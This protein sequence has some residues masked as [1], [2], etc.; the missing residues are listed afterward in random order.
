MQEENKELKE[1]M[2]NI[3]NLYVIDKIF[4]EVSTKK[5][6]ATTQIVYI[7]CLMH[8]FKDKPANVSSSV[9]FELFEDD[10]KDYEKFKKNLQ[11]LHKAGLITIGTK[12]IIFNNVWGK[13]IDRRKLEKVSPDVYVA[14]FQFQPVTAFKQEL[15]NSSSLVE[16]SMMKY[17]LTKTQIIKLIELFVVEQ[18]TF[19]KKYSNFSDCIKHCSY[20]IGLNADKAPKDVVKSTAKI[21]GK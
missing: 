11:E 18:D 19:E 1:T 9:S 2:L 17:K 15:L 3:I 10:F 14:G 13:F 16:L 21:L 12:S 8:H 6:T 4:N 20:W 7:N 5:L